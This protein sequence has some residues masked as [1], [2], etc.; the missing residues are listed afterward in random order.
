[1]LVVVVVL[2]LELELELVLVLR[3]G[4]ERREK[5]QE[6]QERQLLVLPLVLGWLVVPIGESHR[7][8]QMSQDSE[9]TSRRTDPDRRN[10]AAKRKT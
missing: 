2:V 8:P 7:P 1:M 5:S 9:K 6:R 4:V 10:R 3:F